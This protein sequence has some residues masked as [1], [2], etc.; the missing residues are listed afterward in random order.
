M[1]GTSCSKDIAPIAPSINLCKVRY[2]TPILTQK[3]KENV[4]DISKNQSHKE[5]LDKL[6]RNV[7]INSE[8]FDN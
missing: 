1:F 5:T 8:E 4:I 2:T 6:G 3:D 7:F